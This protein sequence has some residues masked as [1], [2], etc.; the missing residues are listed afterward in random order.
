M[1]FCESANAEAYQPAMITPPR[2]MHEAN[3][4][5]ARTNRYSMAPAYT[6]PEHLKAA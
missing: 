6:N 3:M 4:R 1:L 5:E 2:A